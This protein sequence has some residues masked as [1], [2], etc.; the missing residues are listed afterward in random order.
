MTAG[1]TGGHMQ[2]RRGHSERMQSRVQHSSW[3]GQGGDE[4]EERKLSPGINAILNK[5]KCL[6]GSTWTVGWKEVDVRHAIH[7]VLVL[8]LEGSMRK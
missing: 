5:E 8:L 2:G 1:G 7:N 4:S 6:C 3:S